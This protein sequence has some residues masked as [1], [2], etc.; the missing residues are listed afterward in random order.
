[1][2]GG[3]VTLSAGVGWDWGTLG[4]GVGV[5]VAESVRRYAEAA[6]CTGARRTLGDGA[7]GAGETSGTTKETKDR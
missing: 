4:A 2:G 7:H 1:M 3:F 5:C 6:R